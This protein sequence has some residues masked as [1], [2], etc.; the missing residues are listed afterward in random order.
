M[1][2]EQLI[3]SAEDFISKRALA[4]IG[5]ISPPPVVHIVKVGGCL[6]AAAPPRNAI[7]APGH[8]IRALV[9]SQ[10]SPALP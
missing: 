5:G 2:Y 10:C 9:S 8:G 1:A 7:A 4:H 6:A 3:K